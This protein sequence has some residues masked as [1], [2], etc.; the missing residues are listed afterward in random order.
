VTVRVDNVPP[1]LNVTVTPATR[2]PAEGGGFTY[3]DPQQPESYRRDETAR[4]TVESS[5]ADLD[6]ASIQFEV[7]AIGGPAITDLQLT[8]CAPP[9]APFCKTV[10]VPLWRPALNAFRGSFTVQVTGKDRVGNSVTVARPIPVTRWRWAFEGASGTIRSSPAIGQTGTVYFGTSE[11]NGKVF[12]LTPGGAKKWTTDVSLGAV[13]GSVAVGRPRA[14]NEEYVFVG[15]TSGGA[16]QFYALKGT[17]GA[18][19]AR[20]PGTAGGYGSALFE[21]SFAVDSTTG[22]LAYETA[23]AVFNN[24]PTAGRIVVLRPDEALPGDRCTSYTNTSGANLLPSTTAGASVVRSGDDIFF[25][26]STG[27]LTSYRIGNNTPT[28]GWPVDMGFAPHGLAIIGTT[29][30]GGTGD[31]PDNGG[32]FTLPTAGGT[33]VSY[34]YPATPTS[35]VFN[36]AVGAGNIAFFGAESISGNSLVRL[37][38]GNPAANTPVGGAGGR[39]APVVGRNNAL[40]TAAD[41][42]DVTAWTAD[43]LTSRWT[44]SLGAGAPDAS[45]TLDCLREGGG[46]VPANTLGMLYVP[47]GSKLHALIV[48][49]PGLDSNAPWP[50]YQHDLRNSGN[51]ATP[52]TTCQ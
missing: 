5:S 20:C 11:S 43:T 12:A 35:R 44:V 3:A 24:S 39:A 15:A 16:T 18:Q 28:A 13:T 22:T 36:L 1:T 41:N 40:Y 29:L 7:Q 23:A 30:Y 8:D 45:P 47:A 33:T 17:D 38:L 14:G 50:K 31:R 25:G 48:D 10:E 26:T 34:L 49:S 4:V 52:I 2:Q 21:G 42:G 27:R 6:P 9:T 37:E 19:H 46:A 51:P 32:L